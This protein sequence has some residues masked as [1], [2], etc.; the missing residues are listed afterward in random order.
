M[1][2]VRRP[3][4]QH[5]R[6]KATTRERPLCHV[7][8]A[9]QRA[10]EPRFGQRVEGLLDD[11]FVPFDFVVELEQAGRQ[12]ADALSLG[13]LQ[14]RGHLEAR[15]AQHGLHLFQSPDGGV[16]L[17]A[18]PTRQAFGRQAVHLLLRGELPQE[19]QRDAAAQLPEQAQHGRVERLQDGL[20]LVDLG[21]IKIK[22]SGVFVLDMFPK[23]R[24]RREKD[25]RPLYSSGVTPDIITLAKGIANGVPMG[26]LLMSPAVADKVAI[27]DLGS[28]FGGGPLACAA[29][30]AVLGTIEADGLLEQAAAFGRVAR[31]R[32]TVGPVRE[33]IGCGCL[34]GLRMDGDAKPVQQ[35]LLE[36]GFITGTSGDPHVLRLLP[37]INTPSE[38]IEELRK[39]LEELV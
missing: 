31:E 26:A 9:G 1:C 20:Q 12:V 15:P 3:N 2:S 25:S 14:M 33:V 36:H 28:T 13:L 23:R 5:A 21:R 19:L 38:A 22:G 8:G 4:F 7:T 6:R 37:P 24:S 30:L 10:V 32:L 35:R 18:Q 34:I 11:S 27:G 39:A 16:V 29:L 17:T